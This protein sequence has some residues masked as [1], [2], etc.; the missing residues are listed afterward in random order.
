MAL[1]EKKKAG[2]EEID[3]LAKIAALEEELERKTA[4]AS[5]YLEAVKRL[6]ADS[7]NFRKR[8]ERERVQIL[9]FACQDMVCSLLP[10]VD[11]L[12]RAVESTRESKDFEKLAEGVHLIY[13]QLKST[14]AATG[15]E[16]IEPEGEVFDPQLHEAVLQV[17][18]D[19]HEEN[20]VLEVMQKGYCLKG[21]VIRP[22][23]VKV[24]FK[25]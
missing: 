20:T 8:M 25:E 12:E 3:T 22:A 9:E 23:M 16:P 13:E 14:L 10:L 21:R 11:N 17:P 6:Q 4:E 15:V 18:S 24:S 19:D 7:E 1:T 2:A 5:E